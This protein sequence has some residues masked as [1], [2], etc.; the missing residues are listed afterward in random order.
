MRSHF[1]G[2]LAVGSVIA[3]AAAA[4]T[5][6][7]AAALEFRFSFD[8]VSGTI[9]NLVDN[10][11]NQLPIIEVTSNPFSGELNTIYVGVGEISVSA[12]EITS[13]SWYGH[14]PT[15]TYGNYMDLFFTRVSDGAIRGNFKGAGGEYSG[16][17]VLS[18]VPPAPPFSVPGPLPR[19]GTAAA[20]VFNR[21]LRKRIKTSKTPQMMSAVA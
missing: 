19:F 14:S 8:G 17:A 13:M 16:P 6:Q 2:G 7:P 18:V 4:M 1:F 20:F 21:K 5:P 15:E 12:G 9:K 10:K 11:E 3:S